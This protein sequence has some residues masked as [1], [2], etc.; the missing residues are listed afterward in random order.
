MA[1]CAAGKAGPCR[2]RENSGSR[3]E[4]RPL[5]LVLPSLWPRLTVWLALR[6]AGGRDEPALSVSLERLSLTES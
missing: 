5:T 3:L 1:L 2:A 4:L 6:W